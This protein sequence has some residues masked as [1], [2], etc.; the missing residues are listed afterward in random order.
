MKASRGAIFDRNGDELALSVPATT[1]IVNPK[2]VLDPG[3]TAQGARDDRCTSPDAKQQSLAA[4]MQAKQTS[5]VYVA[6][7]VDDVT[8]QSVL[9]L[10]LAGVD[11]YRE[12]TRVVPGGELAKGVI[13]RTDID[14]KGT[15][16]LE[17]QYDDTLT[18]TDGERVSEHDTQGNAIPGSG[19]VTMAAGR[20]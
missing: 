3:G 12:D 14:G 16:G 4:A 1:I 9:A 5:F 6:R 15:A 10:K 8:A 13:G 17:L 11:S 18:G 2:L 19:G 7:Q 20:R